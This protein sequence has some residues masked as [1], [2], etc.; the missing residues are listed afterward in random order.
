MREKPSP[1]QMGP[2][3]EETKLKK[4]TK[5]TAPEKTDQIVEHRFKLNTKGSSPEEIKAA[6]EA[7]EARFEKLGVKAETGAIEK[8]KNDFEKVGI[9]TNNKSPKEIADEMA[10]ITDKIAAQAKIPPQKSR[11]VRKVIKNAIVTLCIA[12][13]VGARAPSPE[14]STDIPEEDETEQTT[15]P[16][17]SS[18]QE[19]QPTKEQIKA[20]TITK[21][22]NNI[23]L[24]LKKQLRADAGLARKLG[25][26]GDGDDEK[27]DTLVHDLATKSGYVTKTHETRHAGKPGTVSYVVDATGKIR[28][29]NPQTGEEYENGSDG[30][31][32]T[33]SLGGITFKAGGRLV[34]IFEHLDDSAE[35][36]G[37]RIR[38][39]RSREDHMNP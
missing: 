26:E 1:E 17:E 30:Y 19:T 31:Q 32:Y 39:V 38:P 5:T 13:G 27:F 37:G 18:A 8:V 15:K 10:R 3:P 35:R 14:H 6:L 24:A 36:G 11:A 34:K 7:M 28:E 23:E 20:G 16:L 33:E 25:Y 9:A 21:K 4:E 2:N 12:V 29:Y 22:V